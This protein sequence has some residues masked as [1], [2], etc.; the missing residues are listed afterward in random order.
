MESDKRLFLMKLAG[1]KGLSDRQDAAGKNISLQA[2]NKVI[3]QKIVNEQEHIHANFFTDSSFH[4]ILLYLGIMINRNIQGEYIE[5]R[6]RISNSKYYMAQDIMKCIVQY[7]H[8][9]ATEHEVQFLSELLAN[10]RYLKHKSVQNNVVQ[11]QMITRQF[12]EKISDELGINL[13][14]DYDFFEKI[15]RQVETTKKEA[16]DDLGRIKRILNH[17]WNGSQIQ[18]LILSVWISATPFPTTGSL[19]NILYITAG[20][21]KCHFRLAAIRDLTVRYLRE[22]PIGITSLFSRKKKPALSQ[23]R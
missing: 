6:K 3:V 22:K 16:W 15:V 5:E 2:G 20:S 23:R 17:N 11:M 9:T 1:Q 14:D 12:V 19:P 13:N 7:C 8:I 10:A 4:K 21:G 18:L